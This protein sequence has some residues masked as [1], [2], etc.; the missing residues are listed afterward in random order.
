MANTSPPVSRP[1]LRAV[2]KPRE[3]DLCSSPPLLEDLGVLL[4]CSCDDEGVVGTHELIRTTD[5]C[6]SVD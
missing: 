5:S 6:F 3:G 4:V 1:I 2:S